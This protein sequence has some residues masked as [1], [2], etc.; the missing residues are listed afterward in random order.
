MSEIMLS[1]DFLT[2]LCERSLEIL[3]FEGAL[4]TSV[5]AKDNRVENAGASGIFDLQ[6]VERIKGT[7]LRSPDEAKFF[8]GE[9]W[10]RLHPNG[11]PHQFNGSVIEDLDLPRGG[12]ALLVDEVESAREKG[13]SLKDLYKE[14]EAPRNLVAIPLFRKD[15]SSAHGNAVRALLIFNNVTPALPP[16]STDKRVLEA[17]AIASGPLA[18]HF[19]QL[20]EKEEG[21]PEMRVP[22]KDELKR[23]MTESSGFEK[24]SLSVPGSGLLR[25]GVTVILAVVLMAVVIGVGPKTA[26]T[27]LATLGGLG[28]GSF[29]IHEAQTTRRGAF[30][31]IPLYVAGFILIFEFVLFIATITSVVKR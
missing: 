18:D 20:L 10:T 14:G 25:L 22:S 1:V 31:S 27:L 12:K 2:A 13:L 9:I 3:P 17:A 24:G 19:S 16:R 6:K 15:A 11:K 30:S 23:Q 5:G 26:W 7:N 4:I 21:R 28:A 8:M 29:L